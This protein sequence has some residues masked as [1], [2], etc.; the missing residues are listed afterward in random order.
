VVR[1]QLLLKEELHITRRRV[2][3]RDS[4]T[5]TLRR[6]EATVERMEP[7]DQPARGE[8]PLRD[9]KENA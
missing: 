9:Q 8:T 5:V 4:R 2:A 1:K 7:G 6:E 3:G